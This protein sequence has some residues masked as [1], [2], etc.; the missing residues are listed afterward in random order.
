MVAKDSQINPL[1]DQTASGSNREAKAMT[2]PAVQ[3]CGVA[4]CAEQYTGLTTEWPAFNE[5]TEQSSN[6]PKSVA[7]SQLGEYSG[8]RF[9]GK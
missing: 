7:F 9:A 5:N 6:E 3:D 1:H 8:E 4:F 2:F